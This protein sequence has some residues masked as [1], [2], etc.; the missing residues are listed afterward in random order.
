MDRVRDSDNL[1]IHKI[2]SNL[3]IE[4]FLIRLGSKGEKVDDR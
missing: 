4:D 2:Y 1:T 3:E